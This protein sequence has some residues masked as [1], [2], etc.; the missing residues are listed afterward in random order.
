MHDVERPNIWHGDTLT[1]K[2]YYGGLF[3]GAPKLYDVVLTNP[4]FGATL[5]RTAA[6]RFN[7]PSPVS[8]V[9]FVQEVIR[10][11]AVGGR[12]GMVVDEDLCSAGTM[13]PCR[14]AECCLS[15]AIWSA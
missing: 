1:R 11:L 6:A 15:G 7:Y 9:L 8:Q 4:P 2:T 14:L 13:R 5:G 10:V 3:K 12:C